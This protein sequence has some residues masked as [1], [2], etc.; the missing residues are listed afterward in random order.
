MALSLGPGAPRSGGTGIAGDTDAVGILDAFDSVTSALSGAWWSYPLVLAIVA[1]D[2]VIPL[3]PGETALVTAGVLSGDGGLSL[4]LV[5]LAGAAGAFLGDTSCY[6]LGR[7]A[8]P[9]ARRT[10]L[11]GARARRSLTWAEAQLDRRGATIV[12]VARFVPGGRTATS[13]IA[14]TTHYPPRRFMAAAAVGAVVWSLYNSLI[15]RI[16]GAAF[17]DQTWK[18]LLAA[19]VIA[20]AGAAVIEVVRHL[21]GRRS[22]SS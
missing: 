18:A 7:W 5:V 11:S 20:L 9:W 10:V 2:A 1:G 6:L 14:G 21:L 3:L 16:G 13:F 19:S 15:G 12:V 8:G 4:P 17:Q 22:A